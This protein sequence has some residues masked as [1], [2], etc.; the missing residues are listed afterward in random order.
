MAGEGEDDRIMACLSSKEVTPLVMLIELDGG[1][2]AFHVSFDDG[3]TWK[4]LGTVAA[5]AGARSI[6]RH[7]KEVA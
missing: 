2:I 5:P 7:P 3:G 6:W 1:K 4:D